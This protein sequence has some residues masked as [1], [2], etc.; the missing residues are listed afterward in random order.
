M[1]RQLYIFKCSSISLS[2]RTTLNTREYSSNLL[3]FLL[4]TAKVP[5]L[6]EIKHSQAYHQHPPNTKDA[7]QHTPKSLATSQ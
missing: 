5:I 1:Y 4:L 2:K 7:K 6:K 3:H